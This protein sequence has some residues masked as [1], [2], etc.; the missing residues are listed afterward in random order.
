MEPNVQNPRDIVDTT[1]SLEAVGAC[2]SMKNFLFVVILVGL[3]LPQIIF[4]MNRLGLIS[5]QPCTP[6]GAGKVSCAVQK[7]AT[8]TST[9]KVQIQPV[10]SVGLIPLAA[11]VNV[12]EEV[13]KVTGQVQQSEQTIEPQVD[14]EYL[15]QYP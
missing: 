7:P 12:A 6:C 3:L 15:R 2:R 5:Q 10:A 9:E 8:L 14:D 4:W 11:E 13:E 1:D